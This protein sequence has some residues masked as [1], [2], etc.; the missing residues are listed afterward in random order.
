MFILEAHWK[1]RSGLHIRV[2]WTLFARCYGWEVTSEY[3]LEISFL[4]AVG[5][6]WLK[7]H[8]EERPPPTMFAR[9]VRPVNILQHCRWRY[10]RK[11]IL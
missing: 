2:D 10:S 9:I 4:K 7:F 5:Q 3:R 8:V 1:A 11:W 6:F